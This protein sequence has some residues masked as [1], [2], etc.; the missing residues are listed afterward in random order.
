M[1]YERFFLGGGV[2]DEAEKRGFGDKQLSGLESQKLFS[3][4]ARLE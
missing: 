2:N 1:N 4:F 3:H